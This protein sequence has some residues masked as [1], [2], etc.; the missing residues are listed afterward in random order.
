MVEDHVA[1]HLF[2]SVALH[3]AVGEAFH[4]LRIKDA[5]DRIVHR[6]DLIHRSLRA[7]GDNEQKTWPSAG[8]RFVLDLH[9]RGPCGKEP[10]PA[11][12]VGQSLAGLERPNV[13]FGGNDL[14]LCCANSAG[15]ARQPQQ[16][17]I[18][19]RDFQQGMPAFAA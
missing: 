4:D 3:E 14:L 9:D 18:Q 6:K 8:Q 1:A 19:D 10:G 13:L 15:N 7:T 11:D 17:Q 5:L 12:V 16:E 2:P